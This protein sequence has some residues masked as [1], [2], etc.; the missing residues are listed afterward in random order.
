IHEGLKKLREADGTLETTAATSQLAAE[1][2]ITTATA[3]T[4]RTSLS[5]I[6]LGLAI[7]G[8]IWKWEALSWAIGA[9]AGIGAGTAINWINEQKSGGTIYDCI[10]PVDFNRATR[11]TLPRVPTLLDQGGVGLETVGLAANI[12]FDHDG[13]GVLAKTGWAGKDDALLVWDRT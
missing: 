2:A 11:W 9:T 6:R 8:Q 1:L 13:D 10:H 5:S 7:S 4:V 3:A 12:H